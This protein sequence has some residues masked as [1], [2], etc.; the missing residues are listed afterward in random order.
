[1]NETLL[2]AILADA[3]DESRWLALSRWLW[4]NGRGDESAAVRVFWPSLR[5]N[6]TEVGLDATLADLTRNATTLGRLARQV[7]D[8]NRSNSACPCQDHP[9]S[10]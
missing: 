6:V 4:D 9:S 2:D 7:G 1:M 10:V 3:G 5:D 8:R